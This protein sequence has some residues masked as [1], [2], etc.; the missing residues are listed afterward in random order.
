MKKVL[1]IG[2]AVAAMG[3]VALAE[4]SLTACQEFAARNDLDA[5]PCECIAEA[6]SGDAALQA[7]QIA[8]VTAED[9]ENAS[10]D[11]HAAIDPCVE[12]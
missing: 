12:G 10:D 11:L 4:D 5:S 1:F 2:A 6:V 7:E 3:G 9:Y 8:L